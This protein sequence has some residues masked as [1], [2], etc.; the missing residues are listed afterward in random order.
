MAIPSIEVTT[1]QHAERSYE[2]PT[3]PVHPYECRSNI[4]NLTLPHTSPASPG[5]ASTH[6]DA[7]LTIATVRGDF[8]CVIRCS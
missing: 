1:V 4:R 3:D 6:S 8:Y 2:R 5:L 7:L